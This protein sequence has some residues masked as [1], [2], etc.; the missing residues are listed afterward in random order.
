VAGIAQA[1]SAFYVGTGTGSENG[2]DNLIKTTS[3]SAFLN[4]KGGSGLAKITVGNELIDIVSGG[5]SINFKTDAATSTAAGT[6][7][8]VIINS[9]GNVG[10]GDTTPDYLLEL[11]TG[12]GTEPAFAL[13]DGDIAHGLTTLAETDVSM[14]LG[15]ISSTAGGSRITGLTDTSGQALELRG[16][17]G[18]TDP[19]DT[20][21]AVKIIGGKSNG[22][23]G[24]ADLGA[25]ETVFQVANTM[26]G[27]D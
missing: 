9:S 19:T 25:D 18:S 2:D 6:T 23:T 15:Q 11:S 26:N 4:L 27:A 13:S 5:S 12:G 3:S 7:R 17:I 20:T 24:I 16:V 10:I 22:S 1:D 8:M 21:P 14:H